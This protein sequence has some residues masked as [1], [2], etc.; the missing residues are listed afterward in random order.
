MNDK[1]NKIIAQLVKKGGMYGHIAKYYINDEATADLLIV[2]CSEQCHIDTAKKLWGKKLVKE[3]MEYSEA[4][5]M[6]RPEIIKF[7]F[8]HTFKRSLTY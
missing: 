1:R 4:L 3:I 6:P 2:E 7:H 8:N 5:N